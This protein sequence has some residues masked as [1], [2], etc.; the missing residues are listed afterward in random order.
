MS[1]ISL[2]G[3]MVVLA[4]KLAG[5]SAAAVVIS[6]AYQRT[7]LSP[8]VVGASRCGIGLVLGGIAG[9][10]VSGFGS[11][12]RALLFLVGLVPVRMIEWWIL[13]WLF[14]DRPLANRK[15]GWKVVCLGTVWSFVLDIPA[16]IGLIIVGDFWG[17]V[18]R[19]F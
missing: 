3:F 5:Y 19:V 16:I 6:K 9:L 11:I 18:G 10:L 7:G 2:L 14:Y 17:M 1:G 12:V 8:F 4:I 13:V 15:L